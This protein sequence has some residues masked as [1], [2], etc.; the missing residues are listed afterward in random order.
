M[1]I[2]RACLLLLIAVVLCLPITAGQK[3]KPRL[4]K[5]MGYRWGLSTGG[6][7]VDLKNKKLESFH[8]PVNI[9]EKEAAALRKRVKTGYPIFRVYANLKDSDIAALKQQINDSRL[10]DFQPKHSDIKERM[11]LIDECPPTLVLVWSDKRRVFSLPL[12]NTVRKTLPANRSRAYQ[13]MDDIIDSLWKMSD[14]YGR[15]PYVS[16]VPV[17]GKEYKAFTQERERLLR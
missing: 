15:K 7:G 3:A 11:P 17:Q 16:A 2:L 6:T 5:V 13:K 12:F 4:I 10:R 14:K 9:S 8:G 1:R